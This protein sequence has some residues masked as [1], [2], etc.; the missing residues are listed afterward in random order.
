MGKFADQLQKAGLTRQL[1]REAWLTIHKLPG[2]VAGSVN[3]VPCT[4]HNVRFSAGAVMVGGRR[5]ERDQVLFIAPHNPD[6]EGR[7]ARAD[8]PLPERPMKP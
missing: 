4:G 3:N 1:V 5:Y 7:S 8:K 2:L 6:V